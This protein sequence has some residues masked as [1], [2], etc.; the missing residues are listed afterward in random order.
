MQK[1]KWLNSLLA[2]LVVFISFSAFTGD[3]ETEE[4]LIKAANK[5]FSKGEYTQCIGLFSQL[6]SNH[7]QNPNYNFKYGTCLLFSTE[8]KEQAIRFLKFA[9]N[10]GDVDPEAYFFYGR[11]LHLN[12]QF[13]NAKKQYNKFSS[14]VNPKVSSE[15]GI[16]T[17]ITQCS[18]AEKLIEDI[19][20]IN[21]IH[22]KKVNKAEFFRS[23]RLGSMKRNI[24]IKPEEFKTKEDKKSNEY[25]LIVH[26]PMNE[27][28]YVSGYNKKDGMGGKD[29]FK[30]QKMPDGTFSEPINIGP[31]INTSEDEDFPYLHPNGK[32]LY[33][34]SKGHN[35]IG[36]YDIFRSELDT[37]LNLWGNAV[38]VGF[39]VNSPDDDV[40]YVSDMDENIAY[41]ASSR[42]NKLGEITVYK[43]LPNSNSAPVVIVRGEILIK[44][45]TQNKAKVV[46][47]DDSGEEV[48]VYTS[49]QQSGAFTMTLEESST[50]SIGITAPGK[51]EQRIKL[52]VPSKADESIISK[53]FVIEGSQLGMIDNSALLANSE[54]KKK[55][56]AESARLNVNQSKDVEFNTKIEKKPVQS[57]DIDGEVEETEAEVI[58]EAIDLTASAQKEFDEIKEAEKKIQKQIDATYF[59]AQKKK[60][61]SNLIKDEIEELS[62]ELAD[63]YSE[64]D[65]KLKR[66]EISKKQKALKVSTTEAITALEVAEVKE[67]ELRI[68][69]K[70]KESAEAYLY[71]I[72]KADKSNNSLASIVALEKARD[73]LDVI[74]E[75]IRKMKEDDGSAKTFAKIDAAKKNVAD[76]ELALDIVDADI[77]DIKR[78]QKDLADRANATRN[79]GLKEEL[80][81]QIKE[82]DSEE[83][84]K[85][86]EQD[87]TKAA[88]TEAQSE[89]D[90]I[91]SSKNIFAEI[92]EEAEDEGLVMMNETQKAQI[93]KDVA[94]VELEA[95]VEKQK[96]EE[97]RIVKEK[98]EKNR[99]KAIEE[100]K[101]NAIIKTNSVDEINEELA[102]ITKEGE[103]SNEDEYAD[104]LK[105]AEIKKQELE[106]I[107]EEK[108]LMELSLNGP[109]S[110]REKKSIQEKINELAIQEVQ[111]I[112]DIREYVDKAKER[113]ETLTEEEKST[114]AEKLEELVSLEETIVTLEKIQEKE[115][116]EEAEVVKIDKTPKVVTKEIVVDLETATDN[117][118]DDLVTNQTNIRTYEVSIDNNW[119]GVQ[120]KTEE[121]SKLK[122]E[123]ITLLKKSNIAQI[124]SEKKGKTSSSSAEKL[125]EKAIEKLFI[126]AELEGEVNTIEF[127]ANRKILEKDIFKNKEMATEELEN[128]ARKVSDAWT[129]A[130]VRRALSMESKD[131][132]EKIKLINEAGELEKNA[133]DAQGILSKK[134]EARKEVVASVKGKVETS[135]EKESEALTVESPNKSNSTL[136][137]NTES[138]ES[139]RNE[140]EVLYNSETTITN[141]ESE[142]IV[143]IGST[144]EVAIDTNSEEMGANGNYSTNETLV[145]QEENSVSID[146]YDVNNPSEEAIAFGNKAG[147]GIEREESFEYGPSS[148]T[149]LELIKAK[150]L[151]N[152]ANNYYY[153]AET[154]KEK[155]NDDPDNAKKFKKEAEK[156][157]KKGKK[158]QEEANTQYQKV[159]AAEIKYNDDEIVFALE[160]EDIVKA[161][162]AK[163]IMKEANNIFEKATEI[164]K[165]AGKE[166]DE[167]KSSELVNEAYQL[168]LN[169]INKQNFILTGELDGE[170]QEDFEDVVFK[171]VKKEEN[172]YT[173]KAA[174]LRKTADAEPDESK[175]N[176][177]FVEAMRYDLAGNT[178]RT[179][180]MQDELTAD[181]I[182]FENNMNFIITARRQSNNNTPANKAYDLELEAYSLFTLAEEV[183]VKSL[184]NSDQVSRIEQIEQSKELMIEAKE[185]QAAAVGKYQESKSAPDEPNFLAKFRDEEEEEVIASTE[186]IE[187]TVETDEISTVD[188]SIE[189]SVNEVE[190]SNEVAVIDES[191]MSTSI[192]SEIV[193]VDEEVITNTESIETT[194]E[195]DETSTLDSSIENSVDE[196]E[197]SNEVAVIDE[198]K[199]STSIESEIVQVDEKEVAISANEVE[200][201]I[202]VN[203]A[204]IEET[205]NQ[206][207]VAEVL[208]Q[209]TSQSS[210]NNGKSALAAVQEVKESYKD[211]TL[212]AKSIEMQEVARVER[213]EVL[214]NQSIDNKNKSEELLSTVDAMENEDDILAT[215]AKANSFRSK[216]EEQEV[217][218]EN[219]E[220]ILKNNIAEAAAMRREAD[221]ILDGLK[222]NIKEDILSEEENSSPELKKIKVFLANENEATEETTPVEVVT[223]VDN[224]V[225]SETSN[226]VSTRNNREEVTVTSLFR[227][228]LANATILGEGNT[229][230]QLSKEEFIVNS[231][232]KY[233][234]TDEIPVDNKM[235]KGIIYQVQVGAFRNKI[236]PAIFN[237]LSPLVGEKTSSGII[238]YKVGYFRGFKSANM[239]KGRIRNLGFR[240]AFVVVFFNGKRITIPDAEYVIDNADESEKF[241]Y[242]NLV[243]DEIQKLKQLGISEEEATADPIDIST[244]LVLANNSN[245]TPILSGDNGLENDLLN[246]GGV[247]F[248]VQVGVFRSPRVS[249]DLHGVSPL[250][251]EKLNNGLLRYSTG[252][253]RGYVTADT[254]KKEV[255]NEG[256]RDAFVIA[257][258]GKSK[259]ST[260][261]AKSLSGND[262]KNS[263]TEKPNSSN[264]AAITFKIQV[265]AYKVP[266]VVENTPVFKNLTAYPISSITRP[267][268][269]LIYMAGAYKT[270]AEADDFRQVV[271]AAGGFDCFV[272]A[273]QNEK[274]IP[275]KTALE[276]L[277][278]Q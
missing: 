54:Y 124:E 97:E 78:E 186:S 168:E 7:P 187:T 128:E 106:S 268:G 88:L 197:T 255:R 72:K 160:N 191:E 193:Q 85:I 91:E 86:V 155:A 116:N 243:L 53:K 152:E 125:K 208:G 178:K 37:L 259:I 65:K 278:N 263:G 92:N 9:I 177:L 62:E 96:A 224:T 213:I 222:S 130:S 87:V 244:S 66:D 159:N 98:A 76:K 127:S 24:I 131:E 45:G 256:V 46:V 89:L 105:K 236:D 209:V 238:R 38:N 230:E 195:T 219:E 1:S 234:S 245:N 61:K 26:N 174:D 141:T 153:K 200:E 156:L 117:E 11:A 170:V 189:N 202:I 39:A 10:K 71:A 251:T 235:P 22:K 74:Q 260:S 171:T 56:I 140:T 275:M 237:G 207:E 6:V 55:I 253:Y 240:D 20:Q 44:G 95:K 196:V 103:V 33:F 212:N 25:S 151:E 214:K 157:L 14:K 28:I 194:A 123:A 137:E 233:S 180:R 206:T 232:K 225:T 81:L 138:T 199:M 150:K 99:I 132:T 60:I 109:G 247:F 147:Y 250:F 167:K 5:H 210:E 121:I 83:K 102:R 192:E 19:Q 94:A 31:D 3:F 30:I 90:V 111:A 227:S 4:D 277:K 175:K 262:K 258:N 239:A 276:I 17:Y 204:V 75:E 80:E 139:T 135:L 223:K 43:I 261:E 218:A 249:S 133:L 15:K 271:I 254:R 41:F 57:A 229:E 122:K 100:E 148:K 146:N 162:S 272:V 51:G 242:D 154:L 107:R 165:K 158:L 172:E 49:Q 215:I 73:N 113:E 47:Y 8:D 241:V 221:L 269:L 79:K 149:K 104:D 69:A 185:T 166:K 176:A 115:A 164:R 203:N 112:K 29:I 211:L 217:E 181:K 184:S 144:N 198:S 70:E 59:V 267:S 143:K 134:I 58:D 257:Y 145:V 77:V 126:A 50:F 93:L 246:I 120:T 264:S 101:E 142:S 163:L 270:K 274:R 82:L 36:G 32:V 226:P 220:I 110:S 21:V 12:Y 18:S 23:Y 2:L 118:I 84:Y 266:I 40:L 63:A 252:V 188:S 48:G 248:T 161:D 13:S 169:A 183:R 205:T 114:N 52:V 27:V 182:V 68:K 179:K 265:G 119:D 136:V 201:E 108:E 64:S 273:L 190:T 173:K 34:A 228:E 231:Q 216:G 129:K 67:K 16:T 35:S 42:E